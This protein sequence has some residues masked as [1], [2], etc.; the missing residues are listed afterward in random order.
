MKKTIITLA[1]VLGLTCGAFA[2]GG[3]LFERGPEAGQ[4]TESGT[5]TEGLINLPGSHGETGDQGAPLGSGALLL[6]GFGAAYL[7]KARNKK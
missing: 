7:L 4:Y 1:M 2:Q 3:G 6:V 5:R